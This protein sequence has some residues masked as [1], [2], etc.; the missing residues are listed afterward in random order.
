MWNSLHSSNL[1]NNKCNSPSKLQ[2]EKVNVTLSD[3]LRNRSYGS[4][5]HLYFDKNVTEVEAEELL[6]QF[7]ANDK[8]FL[9]D[10]F[11]IT[12]YNVSLAH[13]KLH[14]F[15]L[16]PSFSQISSLSLR[17]VLDEEP[18]VFRLIGRAI[19]F[20]KTNVTV[21]LHAD[22]RSCNVE[23]MLLILPYISSKVATRITVGCREKGVSR[24]IGLLTLTKVFPASLK[25]HLH[26]ETNGVTLRRIISMGL[27]KDGK[28]LRIK[29]DFGYTET[30]AEY[31]KHVYEDHSYRAYSKIQARRH[32]LDI[33]QFHN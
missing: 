8:E 13:W 5:Y 12:S 1:G 2:K 11:Y 21:Y 18:R 20:C 19:K 17:K 30:E 22:S 27:R 15:I 25:F 33:S 7:H 32:L 9:R 14:K 26:Q 24:I 28:A 16:S 31:Y 23:G 29:Q 4:L 6:R 3:F 10:V